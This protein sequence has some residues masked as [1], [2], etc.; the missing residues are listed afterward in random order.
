MMRKLGIV[1]MVVRALGL[2]ACTSS[3]SPTT[4]VPTTTRPVPPLI[5]RQHRQAGCRS[6]TAT[7]RSR[8]RRPCTCTTQVG[9]IAG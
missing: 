4:T 7:H 9:P 6:P 3:V 2:A 1:V 5:S 8:S